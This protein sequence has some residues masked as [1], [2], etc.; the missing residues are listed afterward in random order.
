MDACFWLVLNFHNQNSISKTKQKWMLRMDYI[1]TRLRTE[2]A[3]RPHVRFMGLLYILIVGIFLF[4]YI[5]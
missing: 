1:S 3:L 5:E 2:G 4:V